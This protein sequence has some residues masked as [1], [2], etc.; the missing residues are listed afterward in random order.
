M[1]AFRKLTARIISFYHDHLFNRHW[2]EQIVFER[3]NAIRIAMVFQGLDRQQVASVWR[4]FLDW[5]GDS[6]QDFALENALSIWRCQR[7]ISGMPS[8]SEKISPL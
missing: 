4:P 8:C 5:V 1:P 3:G 6:P 7:D 2:G